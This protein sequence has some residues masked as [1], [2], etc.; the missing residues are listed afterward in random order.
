MVSLIF[1]PSITNT[2]SSIVMLDE[3]DT[4]RETDRERKREKERE[5]SV[6]RIEIMHAF[7]AF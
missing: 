1:P 5:E 6:N 4:E 2:T 7:R 3:R